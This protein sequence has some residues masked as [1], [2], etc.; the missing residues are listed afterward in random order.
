MNA[1]FGEK[2]LL[3]PNMQLLTIIKIFEICK[4]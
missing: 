3:I 2:N 4:R 1:L